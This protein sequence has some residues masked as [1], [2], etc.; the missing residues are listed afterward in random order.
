MAYLESPVGEEHTPWNVWH[1][2]ALNSS[3]W[4][5]LP[6]SSFLIFWGSCSVMRFLLAFWSLIVTCAWLFLLP[7]CLLWRPSDSQCS[8]A[9]THL[10]IKSLLLGEKKIHSCK[11]PLKIL[12][13]VK[14]ESL[15][16]LKHPFTFIYI[17]KKSHL[18][19]FILL[20]VQTHWMYNQSQQLSRK[21]LIL[22]PV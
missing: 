1:I 8:K 19:W 22:P 10:T 13:K 21:A 5:V 2:Q 20:T 12:L 18:G 11:T 16:S 9:F 7:Y 15:L 14:S 4:R 3:N 17:K 6:P